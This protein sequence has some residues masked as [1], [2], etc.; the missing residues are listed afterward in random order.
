LHSQ[1]WSNPILEADGTRVTDYDAAST[2]A[3]QTWAYTGTIY[4]PDAYPVG[5]NFEL[6]TRLNDGEYWMCQGTYVDLYGCHGQL[7]F[8]G[9]YTDELNTGKYAIIGG[10]GDFDGAT[11]FIYGEFTHEG[12]FSHRTIYVS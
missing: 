10:T 3:G 9:P 11:G 8:S 7:A 4:D 6:C 2:H 5:S 12:N 1:Q